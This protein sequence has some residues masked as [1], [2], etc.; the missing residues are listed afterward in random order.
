MA[1]NRNCETVVSDM[2]LNNTPQYNHCYQLVVQ[3]DKAEKRAGM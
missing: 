1:G 2:E 3:K